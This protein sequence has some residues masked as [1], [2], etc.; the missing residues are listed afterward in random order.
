MEDTKVGGSNPTEANLG[1]NMEDINRIV[2]RLCKYRLLTQSQIANL[3]YS[4]NKLKPKSIYGGMYE[5]QSL[6]MM[7]AEEAK[8]KMKKI[9]RESG[10]AGEGVE[11]A[12]FDNGIY[13]WDSVSGEIGRKPVTQRDGE[14]FDYVGAVLIQ[15]TITRGLEKPGEELISYFLKEFGMEDW[16]IKDYACF[17]THCYPEFILRVTKELKFSEDKDIAEKQMK[18]CEEYWSIYGNFKGKFESKIDAYSRKQILMQNQMDSLDSLNSLDSLDKKSDNSVHKEPSA[19]ALKEFKKKEK[20]I[21]DGLKSTNSSKA[22]L[23]QKSKS[24]EELDISWKSD[25]WYWT[26]IRSFIRCHPELKDYELNKDGILKLK[27]PVSTSTGVTIM[28]NKDKLVEKVVRELVLPEDQQSIMIEH[29]NSFDKDQKFKGVYQK[30]K[31]NG[32]WETDTNA[33]RE[34]LLQTEAKRIFQEWKVAEQKQK[35]ELMA[36]ELAQREKEE[37]RVNAEKQAEARR[38]ATNVAKYKVVMDKLELHRTGKLKRMDDPEKIIPEI[39]N[40][41]V[42]FLQGNLNQEDR[43]YTMIAIIAPELKDVMGQAQ[44]NV[45]TKPPDLTNP[46]LHKT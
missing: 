5:G 34:S 18:E 17:S 42:K 26:E 33:R 10:G 14:L 43:D 30:I 21:Y 11:K 29:L 45:Q 3:P 9:I 19:S 4:A 36:R 44:E 41:I 35:D 32:I 46:P 38:L 39:H 28:A 15:E 20:E 1:Y 7:G 13:A 2:N 12:Q 8:E 6:S 40:K 25:P 37:A 31:V 27:T 22:Q 24:I 23:L 16:V